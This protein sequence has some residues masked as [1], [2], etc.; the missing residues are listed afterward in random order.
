MD[1]HAE[2]EETPSREEAMKLKPATAPEHWRGLLH[3]LPHT[4]AL[5]IRDATKTDFVLTPADCKRKCDQNGKE[6]RAIRERLW[7]RNKF[8]GFVRCHWCGEALTRE[9]VTKDHIRARCF[10]GSDILANI[11]PACQR[12]NN[13]RS[14]QQAR[15]MEALRVSWTIAE[16]R[17]VA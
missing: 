17:L 10:G 3:V 1:D 14:I 11:V 6:A 7:R 2:G 5:L 13:R 9:Q 15:D 12:C 8:F 4:R 16:L